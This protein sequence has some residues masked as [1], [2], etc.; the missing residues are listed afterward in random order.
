MN[1]RDRF[2]F[3]HVNGLRL[4]RSNPCQLNQSFEQ[5]A[6]ERG[7][8]EVVSKVLVPERP[9]LAELCRKLLLVACLLAWCSKACSSCFVRTCLVTSYAERLK[10]FAGQFQNHHQ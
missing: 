6:A 8:I 5:I 9:Q 4:R 2:C 1:A 10:L 7:R 3:D